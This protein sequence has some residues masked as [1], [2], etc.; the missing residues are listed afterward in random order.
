MRFSLNASFF[1][2]LVFQLQIIEALFQKENNSL[3][4]YISR[5]GQNTSKKVQPAATRVPLVSACQ[6][7]NSRSLRMKGWNPSFYLVGNVGHG[8]NLPLRRDPLLEKGKLGRDLDDRLP[9]RR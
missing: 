5:M 7:F 8:L 9:R 6:N 2:N 1:K 4:K 3:M